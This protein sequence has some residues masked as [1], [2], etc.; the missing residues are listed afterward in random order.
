MLLALAGEP[1][2]TGLR[3]ALENDG[4]EVVAEADEAQAAVATAS[5]AR[6]DLV[7][8]SA[9]LPGGGLG[10]A[11]RIADEHPPARLVVL[12]E[13]PHGEELV[14]SVLAG[15][16]GYLAIE[17]A[18]GRLTQALHGVL[19]GEVALPR[20][21]TEHLL[22]ELRGRTS[23]RAAIE[24]RG[25]RPITDREWEVLELLASGASSAQVAGRLGI[26]EV[27]VRR[28]AAAAAGKLGVADRAA[29]IQIFR[30]RS[31]R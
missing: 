20:R 28:H 12:T 27:T 9:T 19:A 8:L 29:A 10:A 6:P 23:R 24:A 3:V 26:S 17:G 21:Y 1:T 14:Q 18:Q 5:R 16:S 11:R 31:G 15:A 4:F 7:L 22:D 2:R 30:V 13:R 25:S